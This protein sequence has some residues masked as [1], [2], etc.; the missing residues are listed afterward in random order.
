MGPRDEIGKGRSDEDQGR[1]G[2]A[3]VRRPPVACLPVHACEPWLHLAHAGQLLA[4][5]RRDFGVVGPR[6]LP[7]SEGAR[8]AGGLDSE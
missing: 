4:Q 6:H 3:R 2:R 1:R 7:R 8:G 5:E